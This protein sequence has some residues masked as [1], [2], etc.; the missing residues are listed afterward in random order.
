[1]QSAFTHTFL[2]QKQIRTANECDG[3]GRTGSEDRK[4]TIMK[5]IITDVK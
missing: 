5:I 4:K 2:K 3:M 1:M